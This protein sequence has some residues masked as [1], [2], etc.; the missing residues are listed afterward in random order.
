MPLAPDPFRRLL[1]TALLATVAS[2]GGGDP[3][4]PVPPPAPP[5]APPP[6]GLG[7]A[8][9]AATETREDGVESN[10]GAETLAIFAD[11][12]TTLIE[13]SPNRAPRTPLLGWRTSR[14]HEQPGAVALQRLHTE[15]A[16]RVATA[17]GG[18]G[19]SRPMDVVPRRGGSDRALVRHAGSDLFETRPTR[20]LLRRS[21]APAG[22]PSRTRACP[23][24]CG[25]KPTSGTR[26]ETATYATRTMTGRRPRTGSGSSRM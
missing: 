21:G 25:A 19:P 7:Q 17:D 4:G 23:P 26:A 24:R 18:D 8:A 22:R 20:S 11:A 3:Q 12:I 13:A 9:L 5:P 2:C 10:A 16:A 1:A 14:A 6:P 15:I